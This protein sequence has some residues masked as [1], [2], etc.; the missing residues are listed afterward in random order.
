MH[1]IL[2]FINR[3]RGFFMG[4]STL[5]MRWAFILGTFGLMALGAELDPKIEHIFRTPWENRLKGPNREVIDLDFRSDGQ[6]L[7]AASRDSNLYLWDFT[8][9]ENL[10]EEQRKPIELPLGEGYATQVMFCPG[11]YLVSAGTNEEVR[12]WFT[13]TLRQGSVAAY[14][15]HTQDLNSDDPFL[16]SY[17]LDRHTSVVDKLVLSPNER[18]LASA[19][20]SGTVILWNTGLLPYEEY[21]EETAI[22]LDLQDF[23]IVDIEFSSTGEWLAISDVSGTIFLL[24][25]DLIDDPYNFANSRIVLQQYDKLVNDLVFDIPAGNNQPARYLYAAGPEDSILAYN[26][27]DMS[28]PPVTF[29][30]AH[31]ATPLYVQVSNDLGDQ[32][33]HG[34]YWLTS[35]DEDGVVVFWDVYRLLGLGYSYNTENYYQFQLMNQKPLSMQIS[36]DETK[37]IGDTSRNLLIAGSPDHSVRLVNLS[38]EAETWEYI[39]LRS[40]FGRIKDIDITLDNEYI[41]S[42]SNNRI[43]IWNVDAVSNYENAIPWRSRFQFLAPILMI[44][45]LMIQAAGTYLMQVY[46]LGSRELAIQFLL[47]SMFGFYFETWRGFFLSLLWPVF[48]KASVENGQLVRDPDRFAYVDI[49]GGPGRIQV[50]PGNVASFMTNRMQTA[51][52]TNMTYWLRPFERLRNVIS[53][54]EQHYNIAEIE[55]YTREGIK[56]KVKNIEI[57]YRI[58]QTNAREQWEDFRKKFIALGESASERRNL[59]DA[60]DELSQ[61]GIDDIKLHYRWLTTRHLEILEQVQNLID[62]DQ[63]LYMNRAPHEYGNVDRGA[64]QRAIDNL[65]W[66]VAIEKGLEKRIKYFINRH[67]LNYFTA[68]NHTENRDNNLPNGHFRVQFREQVLKEANSILRPIG[69]EVTFMDVG[70]FEIN[71]KEIETARYTL[72]QWRFRENADRVRSQGQASLERARILGRIEGERLIATRIAAALDRVRETIRE[73]GSTTETNRRAITISRLA[74]ILREFLHRAKSDGYPRNPEMD[75]KNLRNGPF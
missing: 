39:Q 29:P 4:F 33:V 41:A 12:V 26:L 17:T 3:F 57:R 14:E 34:Q 49:I 19:D 66:N 7:A 72:W 8:N 45:V 6:W 15:A 22:V 20:V 52:V 1:S 47:N 63:L 10:T 73:S 44:Y 21:I 56:V 75:D 46:G 74:G 51:V 59:A 68:P 9:F 32:E 67:H 2:N 11:G 60:F 27:V 55:T 58:P 61:F 54:E 18:W 13:N 48:P 30:F 70:T 35:I 50:R 62:E 24:D 69:A 53:L 31:E 16:N 37:P 42:T 65:Y 40:L 38:A 25:M 5:V 64:L 71:R 36:F 28:I 43:R 23:P